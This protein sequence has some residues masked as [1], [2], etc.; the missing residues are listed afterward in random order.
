[1]RSADKL[2]TEQA[3]HVQFV[4]VDIDDTLTQEGKLLPEAFAALWKLRNAGIGVIPVTGRPA[5]WCDLIV[6][7]WPVEAVIGENGA[8]VF[9]TQEGIQKELHHPSIAPE[10][11]RRRLDTVKRAVLAEVEDSRIAKDQRFR[12]YD[13]AID[14]REDPPRLGLDIAEQIADICRR[15]GAKARISSI[16][17]N[18][19]FGEYDK[20]EMVKFFF[21]HR[22]N[23]DIQK[24]RDLVLFCGDSPNDEP[25][26][27]FFPLSCAVANIK[28]MLRLIENTPEFVTKEP[29][30]KGFAELTDIILDTKRYRKK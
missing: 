11:V 15:F 14:F 29:Y 3:A 5:G 18:T 25:M 6:R 16:H 20:L 12:L 13:L 17:V 10:K 4:C 22:W 1:M 27:S 26:F 28:P 9:Y 7:Q 23:I 21:S 8:F 30:G 24:N 2:T 19:W